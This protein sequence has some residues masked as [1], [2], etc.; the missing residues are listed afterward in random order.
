MFFRAKPTVLWVVVGFCWPIRVTA[1]LLG[2]LLPSNGHKLFFF[3]RKK[4]K[5]RPKS[6][7]DRPLFDRT[8]QL[9]KKSM[10]GHRFARGNNRFE[11]LW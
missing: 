1:A 9:K 5:F 7:P 10:A 6:A 2:R 8:F 11:V 4:Q 3:Q